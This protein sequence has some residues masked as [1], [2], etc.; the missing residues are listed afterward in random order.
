LDSA[1]FYINKT[2]SND[3]IK[4]I[5]TDTI[6][7][8]SSLINKNLCVVEDNFGYMKGRSVLPKIES[9]L[10]FENKKKLNNFVINYKGEID[11]NFSNWVQDIYNNGGLS[12]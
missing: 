6:I 3:A 10:T 5:G 11:S 2:H 4:Y 7:L 9:W 1:F 12:D 8:I